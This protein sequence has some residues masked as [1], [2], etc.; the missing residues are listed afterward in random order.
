MSDS[1]SPEDARI[2][3]LDS[4]P[5][6][7]ENMPLA[8]KQLS[9]VGILM[10]PSFWLRIQKIIYR[11]ARDKPVGLATELMAQEMLGTDVNTIFEANLINKSNTFGGL[12]HPPFEPVGFGSVIP[13]HFF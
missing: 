4:F 1:L 6:Y 9:D 3:V 12:V 10:F 5:D 7:N 13:Q 2:K 8:I 11:M